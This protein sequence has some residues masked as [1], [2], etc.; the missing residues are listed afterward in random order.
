MSEPVREPLQITLPSGLAEVLAGAREFSAAVLV[1]GCVRDAVLGEPPKDIDV[2]VPGI[3]FDALAQLLSGFGRVDLVGRA[4][5]VVKLQLPGTDTVDFSVPRRDSK[6]GAGH[7]GFDVATDPTITPRAAAARRDFTLNA[8]AWDPR[9]RQVI[10]YFGGLT[11]LRQRVLR[12]TSDAFPEDPL[13]VLRGMQLAARFDLTGAPETLVLCRSI[14]GTFAELPRERV[15][16]EWFKWAAR[17][18]VPSAGLRFLRAS[19]W[20]AHF[21]ELEALAGVEQDP[22]WHPEGDVWTHT[23]HALDALVTSPVWRA[24]DERTRVV[25]S[26]AVLLHDAGKASTTRHEVRNGIDRVVSPSHETVSEQLATVFLARL[27]APG[28][29]VERVLPLVTQ[30]MA[31]LT[32]RTDRAVRR[33]ARRLEPE[34]IASLAVVIGADVAGR[35]PLPHDPPET[36]E[37][38]LETAGRLQLA[39]QAPRPILLGRHLLER[40]FAPGPAMGEVLDEAFEAQLDGAF[41]DLDGA[42]A[43]LAARESGLEN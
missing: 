27:G 9:T 13:R 17:A 4:F 18:R 8:L 30:H 2:E 39:T 37:D 32:C 24:A 15:C 40:G 11:D 25:W 16:A 34:T 7:R 26:L 12:H 38:L 5:G 28:W 10:D 43:W 20:I 23:L 3:D 35:P 36:L 14:A 29:T 41:A 19:G 33:L 21:P 31:H 22:I 42:L 6:V 1:G